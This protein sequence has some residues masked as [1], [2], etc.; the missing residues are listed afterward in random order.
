VIRHSLGSLNVGGDS[1]PQTSGFV[2]ACP[3]P[4]EL[5]IICH[6]PDKVWGL[7]TGYSHDPVGTVR[8][9]TSELVNACKALPDFDTFQIVHGCGLDY[10]GEEP[11]V[12]RL[13]REYMKQVDGARDAAIRCLKEP[14]TGCREGEGRRKTA[15][16][17]IGLVS[18]PSQSFYMESVK[19]EEYEV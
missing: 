14:E 13:R 15:L 18:G 10:G 1:P 4:T 17:V 7:E 8:S 5:T 6:H 12:N 11:Q 2:A 3:K 9:A 19:V 16:R